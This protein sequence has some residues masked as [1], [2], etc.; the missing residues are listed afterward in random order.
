MAFYRRITG[1]TFALRAGRSRRVP[2]SRSTC[3]GFAAFEK[4]EPRHLLAF[5]LTTTSSSYTVDTGA[6]LVFSVARTAG[7]GSVGDLTSTKYNGTELE[8]P[9]SA[10]SRH[11]H[12]ESG[13]SSSTIV[14]AT[15]DPQGNWIKITCD[16]TSGVGVIQY[17]VARK[18]FNNIYMATYAPGPS[19][20]SPG[21]MRFITYTNHAVLTNAPAPSNLTGN[22]G[23]IES[24]DVFGFADG[25]TASKYY[26][27][28]RIIDD[29]Y[30]GVTGGGF[31]VFMNMGN[32]ES[33]SGGPF[34]KDIDFQTTSSQST[35]VYNYM[36][37]GHSQTE[38]FRPG[39]QGPYALQFTTG[40]VPPALDYS[41]LE[42]VGLTGWV[43]AAQRGSL[44]GTASGVPS[45]H[46]VTVALINATA[47]YRRIPMPAAITR[48]PA[49]KR[50]PT[51]RRSIKMNWQWV[52]RP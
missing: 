22:T 17:Y 46:E 35:E 21:E 33:S 34:M 41:F 2:F 45:G 8:A 50:E 10:T 30:H 19:S 39:L 31:G 1:T 16:D 27:E 36:F 37:S 40:G 52:R 42:G 4:L 15:V 20:P 47:Q 51:P 24:Q 26:G 3:H 49:S 44:S 11:S 9:F 32:R 29:P 38:N 18:G 25:T 28:Y 23:A 48:L 13:L 5:G 43:A 12:Y 7:N 14:T 6:N